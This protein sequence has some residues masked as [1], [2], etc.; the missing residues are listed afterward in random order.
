MRV[1]VTGAAGFIGSHVVR[2]LVVSGQD[3]VGLVRPTT[4]L[5]RLE[6]IDV[7]LVHAAEPADVCVHSAWYAVPGMYLEGHENAD[8]LRD[9]VQLASAMAAMG[10]GKFVGI[11]TCIEYD[12]SVVGRGLREDDALRPRTFYAACKLAF[13][14]ALEKLMPYAWIRP[15]HM[16]GP[17]EDER[18]LIPSVVRALLRGERVST[19]AGGRRLDYLHIA[20][21][22]SGICAVALGDTTGV[23]N[24]CSGEPALVAD[25]LTQIGELTGRGGLIE[26]SNGPA[27]VLWGENARLRSTGWSPKFTV[28]DGLRDVVEWWSARQDTPSLRDS[29]R[30]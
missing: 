12:T 15:F 28:G 22:A 21:V 30:G 7:R 18:R 2:E 20:D 16:Y 17:F 11:G 9:S 1:L 4:D 29:E 24:V 8:S 26:L 6:G 23:V 10:C 3:V 5:R 19:A 27:D 14:T 13:L 25:M